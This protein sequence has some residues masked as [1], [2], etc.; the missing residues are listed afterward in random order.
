MLILTRKKGESILI[1]EDV[2]LTIISLSDGL[3][4]IGFEAPLDVPIVRDDVKR[5]SA[6]D[7]RAKEM[8]RA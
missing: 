5:Q 4:K 3:V 7:H 6:P 2:R 8:P 1:A